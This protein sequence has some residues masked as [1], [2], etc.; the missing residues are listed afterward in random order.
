M[1][2]VIANEVG[3]LPRIANVT[4]CLFSHN[5]RGIKP[6]SVESVFL[7]IWV[8]AASLKRELCPMTQ[9]T[10]LP[11]LPPARRLKNPHSGG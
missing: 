10:M 8:T 2:I 6:V 1:T 4:P 11:V 7:P 9:E 3:S 5:T